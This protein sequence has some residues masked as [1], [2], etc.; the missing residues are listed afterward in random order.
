MIQFEQLC[1]LLGV[2]GTPVLEALSNCAVL[3]QGCWV[4]ASAVLYPD[5][6]QAARRNARDYI[7]SK[8]ENDFY[9]IKNFTCC[10]HVLIRKFSNCF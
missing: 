4:V 5:S 6:S 2:S 9:V 1:S 10:G 8:E 7:V 3:V